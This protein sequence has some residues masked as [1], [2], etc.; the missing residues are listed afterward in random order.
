MGGDWRAGRAV[1]GEWTAG[2]LVDRENPVDLRALEHPSPSH[3][4]VQ[5]CSVGVRNADA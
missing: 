2:I 5:W 1:A 3:R 4:S